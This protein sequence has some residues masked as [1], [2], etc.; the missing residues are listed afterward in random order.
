M[1]YRYSKVKENL[2]VKAAGWY[3]LLK[4]QGYKQQ[5]SSVKTFCLFIGYPRSGHSIVGSLLDAHPNIIIANELDVLRHFSFG[6]TREQIFYL[7]LR[8]SRN[9]A[10]KGRV[11][12]GYNYDVPGQWQGRFSEV[13]VIGDKKGGMTTRRIGRNY[14]LLDSIAGTVGVPVKYVHMVRNPFDNITT[15]AL[16]TNSTLEAEIQHYF[17]LCRINQNI[18]GRLKEQNLLEIR[19]EDLI[20]DPGEILRKLTDFLNVSCPEDYIRACSAIVSKKTSITRKKVTWPQPLID[21]VHATIQDYGFL[22]HYAYD[23]V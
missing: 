2:E 19:H 5:F 21:S 11:Q 12:T 3:S 23:S 18:A 16:R 13:Q 10:R 8:N 9:Y 22:T 17:E 7:L 1:L 14:D 15:M 20:R 4:A 6:M